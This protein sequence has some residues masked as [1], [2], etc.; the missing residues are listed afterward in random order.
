LGLSERLAFDFD[1]LDVKSIKKHMVGQHDQS[2]HAGGK[3]VAGVAAHIDLEGK[4]YSKEAQ[5]E[6][7][8]RYNAFEQARFDAQ[9]KAIE[10]AYGKPFSEMTFWEQSL[11]Q[12]HRLDDGRGNYAKNP[13]GS[14]VEVEWE[15]AMKANPAYIA[16]KQE[17][18]S[19]Y[20]FKDAMSQLAYNADG[21]RGPKTIG[22][23]SKADGYSDP[24]RDRFLRSASSV[25]DS[26]DYSD[27][28]WSMPETVLLRDSDGKPIKAD[29]AYQRAEV[30]TS[31][32]EARSIALQDLAEFG[33]SGD[34]RLIVSNKA[35]RSILAD[36]RVKTYT[37]ENRPA[38]AGATSE[39][40]KNLRASYESAAFGYSDS[41]DPTLR[42]VSAAFGT[43]NPHVDV[44]KG[45]GGTQIILK[46]DVIER[47][48]FTS[49]DSLN[50][51]GTPS[52]YEDFFSTPPAAWKVKDSALER[53]A[54]NRNWF[55][56]VSNQPEMQIH[57]GVKT[58]DIARVVFQEKVPDALASKLD[59]LGI[60]YEVIPEVE[61]QF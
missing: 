44:L 53:K 59:K 30:A 28:K 40:Y 33:E 5:L 11:V 61:Q 8:K 9:N 17:L 56:D 60:P 13:D 50:S 47:S 4:R 23:L 46:R 37:E 36:G 10:Q 19:H 27:E 3:M 58:S 55:A 12:A 1:E 16:A 32:D 14:D 25:Y 39:N 20:L 45:Y 38:R 41:D 42:P 6:L 26:G 15:K 49:M 35:L 52:S 2:M 43:T 54:N 24:P 29:G 57:G 31:K 22:E 48:T 34:P 21:T 18:E 51:F 7:K